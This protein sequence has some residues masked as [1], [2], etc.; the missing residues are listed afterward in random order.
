MSEECECILEALDASELGQ[1]RV[2]SIVFDDRSQKL[3]KTL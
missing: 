3:S 1:D 2:N